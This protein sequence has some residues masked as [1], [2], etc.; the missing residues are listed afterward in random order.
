MELARAFEL[1]GKTCQLGF[2]YKNQNTT[3]FGSQNFTVNTLIGSFDFNVPFEG[4][5]SVI[6]SAAFVQAQATGSEYVLSGGNPPTLAS[7]SFYLDTAT[8]GQYTFT[9]LNLTRRTLAF[10]F[11]YPLSSSINFRGDLFINEYAWADVPGYDRT[12]QIMRFT[13]EAHF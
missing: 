2:D 1:K 6:L 5:D 8:L 10:G 4:F 7:Y 9:P 3:L 13:Y 12:D 11:K